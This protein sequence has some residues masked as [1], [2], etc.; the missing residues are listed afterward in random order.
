V[1]KVGRKQADTRKVRPF[2]GS[3]LLSGPVQVPVLRIRPL[4]TG[5]IVKK[6]LIALA[7]ASTFVLG[8]ASP[9]LAGHRNKDKKNGKCKLSVLCKNRV[10]I[11]L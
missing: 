6:K 1:P 8:S 4:L 3:N 2:R 5:G 7:L 9:A 10:D 11:E